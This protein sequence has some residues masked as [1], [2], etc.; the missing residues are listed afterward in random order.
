VLANWCHM[1][2]KTILQKFDSLHKDFRLHML[3]AQGTHSFKIRIKYLLIKFRQIQIKVQL[4]L[5]RFLDKFFGND[6]SCVK[7]NWLSLKTR[8]DFFCLI[9]LIKIN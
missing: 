1:E 6:L 5:L 8:L 7:G 3:S 4:L 2:A 9:C